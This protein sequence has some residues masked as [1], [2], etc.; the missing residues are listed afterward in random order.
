MPTVWQGNCVEQEERL[1]VIGSQ[2]IDHILL[3]Q[4]LGIG[5]TDFLAIIARKFKSLVIAVEVRGEIGMR[6]TLAVVTKKVIKALLKRTASGVEHPHAP[7]AH[8]GCRVALFLEN[9]CYRHGFCR[10]RQLPLAVS[11]LP[12]SPHWTM[13]TMQA[14]HQ[15]RTAGSANGGAA[16]RLCI[17][18]PFFGHPIKTRSLDQFLSITANIPLCQIVTE[19][20][21][22]VRPSLSRNCK[23]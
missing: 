17:T 9:L 11:Y 16:I 23:N 3:N 14:S 8:T 2:P 7:L 13:T 18:R 6:V 20:E 12:V 1:F 4:V 19:N 5:C 10:Q 21:N 15:R 22:D